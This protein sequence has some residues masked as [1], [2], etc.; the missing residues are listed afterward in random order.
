VDPAGNVYV[1]DYANSAVKEIPPGCTSSA[2]VTT[3][4]GG[5][6]FPMG[7]T[8]DAFGTVIVGD[9]GNGKVKKVPPGCVTS[10]C[11]VTLGGGWGSVLGVTAY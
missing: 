11:V 7:L 9:T 10:A 5:F 6:E 1:D 8:V 3:I 2:C 4:G